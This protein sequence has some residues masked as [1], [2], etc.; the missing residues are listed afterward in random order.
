MREFWDLR[1]K[2][3]RTLSLQYFFSMRF[4]YEKIHEN[5]HALR[6]TKSLELK[7]KIFAT[8]DISQRPMSTDESMIRFQPC[9][10]TF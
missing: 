9:S 10:P 6:R 3:N 5:T 4:I 8:V 2:R 7:G 1:A